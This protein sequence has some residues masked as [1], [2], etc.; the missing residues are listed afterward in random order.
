MN[1]LCEIAFDENGLI[2]KENYFRSW[3]LLIDELPKLFPGSKPFHEW[4]MEVAFPAFEMN[5]LQIYK[6]A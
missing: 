3:Q 6:K 4:F 1:N 2:R 5:L